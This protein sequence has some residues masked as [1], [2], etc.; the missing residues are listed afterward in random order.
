MTRP[1]NVGTQKK[2]KQN[3]TKQ[4]KTD[5]NRTKKKIKKINKYIYIYTTIVEHAYSRCAHTDKK[6]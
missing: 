2:T 4:I 1:I 5:K 6:K 3:K